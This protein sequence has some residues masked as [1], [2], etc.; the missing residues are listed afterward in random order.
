MQNV[1][2]SIYYILAC[3]IEFSIVIKRAKIIMS[4]IMFI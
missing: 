1:Y 4:N 3:F 2:N